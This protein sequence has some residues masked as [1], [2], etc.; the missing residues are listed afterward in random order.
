MKNAILRLSAMLIAV[1]LLAGI[2]LAMA[3]D[4]YD[5]SYTYTYDF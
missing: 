4:G 1:C 3:A 2:P 5:Y